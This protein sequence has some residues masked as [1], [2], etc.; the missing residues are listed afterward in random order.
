VGTDLND[1][2]AVAIEV[3]FLCEIYWRTL[4]AGEPNILTAQQM[5]DVKQKFV[6]YKKRS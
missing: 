4:Q 6:E 3:E 1:A 2:L 5:H